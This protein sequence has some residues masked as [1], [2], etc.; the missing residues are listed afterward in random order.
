MTKIIKVRATS[1]VANVS[2]GFDCIGYS[3][4]EPSDD[5]TIETKDKPGIKIVISGLKAGSIPTAAE[6]NTAGKA[7]LSLLDSLDINRGF[8]VHIEKGIPPGSG[9]GSSAASAAAAVFGVNELLGKPLKLKE[10]LVHGIAGEAVSSGGLHADNIA[11]ALFGGII[12]I[13]SYDPLDILQLPVPENLFSTAVLPDSVINTREA[14][15]IMPYR[16]P[17]KSAVEQAGNLAGFTHGLHKADFKLLGRSMVDL[18]AEP[19]RAELIPGYHIVQKVAM[20]T[21]AIGCGI[22]GSGPALFALSDSEEMAKKVGSA[23][24]E[25]FK[26]NKLNSIAYSSSIH[27]K[28]PEIID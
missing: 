22:S 5:L 17:L 16:V 20:D 27:K 21:G 8:N 15:K 6:N 12:L 9:L 18:F 11:P 7:I 2:C 10:L 25:A 26:K 4:G 3:I 24:V 1:S 28:S 13:R 23:M 14:R 19:V